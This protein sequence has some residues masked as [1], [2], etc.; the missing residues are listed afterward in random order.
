MEKAFDTGLDRREG[1]G[2]DVGT[3]SLPE[4]PTPRKTVPPSPW[5]PDKEEACDLT[6]P[7]TSAKASPTY[8][9][10]HSWM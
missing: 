3:R 10:A 4:R 2:T 6:T 5:T 8:G 1:I 9:T 7:A